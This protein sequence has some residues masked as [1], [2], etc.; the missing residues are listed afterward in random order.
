MDPS[1]SQHQVGKVRRTLGP[2]STHPRRSSR[3]RQE[4]DL[5][6]VFAKIWGT[7]QLLVSF[8]GANISVPLGKNANPN[9]HEAW[10]HVD[11]WVQSPHVTVWTSPY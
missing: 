7:D 10:P 2:P 3:C 11:Q 1:H 4:P 9:I 8:D 5:V 6:E